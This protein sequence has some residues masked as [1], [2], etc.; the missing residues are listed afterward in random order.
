MNELLFIPLV[1]LLSPVLI[2]SVLIVYGIVYGLLID[3][4]GPMRSVTRRETLLGGT[5]LMGDI[6]M[7][8]YVIHACITVYFFVQAS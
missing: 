8:A 5:L 6:L 3:L 4:G 2:G 1:M 7:V